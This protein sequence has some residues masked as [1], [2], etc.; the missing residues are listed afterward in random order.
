VDEV[1]IFGDADSK[2]GELLMVD[3]CKRY[4]RGIDGSVSV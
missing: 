3:D 2:K 4:G 1:G